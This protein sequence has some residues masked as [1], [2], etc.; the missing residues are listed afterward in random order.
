MRHDFYPRLYLTLTQPIIYYAHIAKIHVQ[1]ITLHRWL[2]LILGYFTQ[3][4]SKFKQLSSPW[5]KVINTRCLGHKFPLLTGISMILLKHD[6]FPDPSM[7]NDFDPS[8]HLQSHLD[9]RS[10]HSR[11]TVHSQDHVQNI[12]LYFYFVSLIWVTQCQVSLNSVQQFQRRSRKCLSQSEAR[13]A[14]LFF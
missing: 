7:C 8:S 9:P 11:I 13:A 10:P 1:A 2:G 5:P 6:S 3:L 14:I 4:L 12:I